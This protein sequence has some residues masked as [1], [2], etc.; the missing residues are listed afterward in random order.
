MV[1]GPQRKAVAVLQEQCRRFVRGVDEL[2]HLT[3]G[4]TA[5]VYEFAGGSVAYFAPEAP[6]FVGAG[7][8]KGSDIVYAL[9]ILDERGMRSGNAA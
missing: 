5:T 3:E 2:Y 7:E 4:C 1:A 6:D 8:L 9:R